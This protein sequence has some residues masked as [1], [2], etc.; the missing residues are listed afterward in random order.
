[1]DWDDIRVFLAV[2]RG[3]GLTGAARLLNS[4]AQTMGR[5]IAALEENVGATLF[6][7]GPAGYSLT[8]DGQILL[9][10]AERIEEDVVRFHA[11]A[12]GRSTALAGTVRIAAAENFVTQLLVPAIGP[13]LQRHPDLSLEFITGIAPVSLSRGDADLAI[14]LIR[15]DHGEITVRQIGTMLNTLYASNEYLDRDPEARAHPLKAARLIGWDEAHAHLPAARWLAARA[16]RRPDITFTALV[17]QRAATVAGL[18][19]GFLPRFLGDGLERLPCVEPL[20]EPI[21]LVG[22]R[23]NG[24]AERVRAVYEE[25]ARIM[26][27]AQ[28]RLGV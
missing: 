8:E 14:R 5:R 9:A 2:A 13:F 3:A 12:A 21:W 4:S 25:V 17:T 24:A 10:D 19:V 6:I 15:P 23:G 1:M 16:N 22:H 18:G 20:L 7:R 28:G 27:E 26:T 11:N